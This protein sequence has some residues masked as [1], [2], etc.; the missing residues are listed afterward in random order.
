M[1]VCVTLRSDDI[2]LN[3]HKSEDFF[4][5]NELEV[6]ETLTQITDNTCASDAVIPADLRVES[7]MRRAIVSRGDL[8]DVVGCSRDIS[9]QDAVQL[10]LPTDLASAPMECLV[11]ELVC[12]VGMFAQFRHKHCRDEDLLRERGAA[13][14]Q[15]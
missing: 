10:L 9:G 3:V 2:R 8:K 12:A 14:G 7:A 5:M 15:H 6:S 11:G 1:I 4:A 13:S